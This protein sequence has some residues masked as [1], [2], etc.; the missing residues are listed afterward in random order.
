[1]FAVADKLYELGIVK[2]E[3]NRSDANITALDNILDRLD[4]EGAGMDLNDSTPRAYV[5]YESNP[6]LKEVKSWYCLSV[7]F[8]LFFFSIFFPVSFS[9]TFFFVIFE[10]CTGP[11]STLLCLW[12]SVLK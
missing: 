10:F 8:F 7:L 1:M 9:F 3:I 6:G 5:H 4:K 2:D 11:S 12:V